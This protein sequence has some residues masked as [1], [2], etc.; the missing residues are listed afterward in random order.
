MKLNFDFDQVLNRKTATTLTSEI[1]LSETIKERK[2]EYTA[3]NPFAVKVTLQPVESLYVKAKIEVSGHLIVPSTRSLEPAD[4]L[5][6]EKAEEVFC[7]SISDF[8]ADEDDKRVINEVENN[9]IDL[10]NTIV[11]Y[12][13]LA[14][15]TQ[16]LTEKEK[17]E[18]FMP[19]GKDWQVISEDDFKMTR[20]KP[21]KFSPETISKLEELKRNL[22]EEKND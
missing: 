15:P 14:V 17:S 12:V 9:R 11:D 19:K 6:D 22:G 18:H 13:L 7:N 8:E 3:L 1:D 2:S 16:V 21:D 10:Y 4:V 5:I 20:K